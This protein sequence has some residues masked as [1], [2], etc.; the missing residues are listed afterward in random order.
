[1]S[2]LVVGMLAIA[3]ALTTFAKDGSVRIHERRIFTISDE[4][5][6]VLK[7]VE[8]QAWDLSG[9]ADTLQTASR[10]S[11][12]TR[13]FHAEELERVRQDVNA[14]GSE[15]QRLQGLEPGESAWEQETVTRVMPL[16]RQVAATTGRTIGYLNEYPGRIGFAEYGHLTKELSDQSTDLSKAL[17][18]SIHL[19][20]LRAKEDHLRAQLQ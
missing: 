17:H 5:E 11:R 7:D 20:E 19:A 2:K 14:I 3:G 10:N 8:H 18:D 16:L 12:S 13:E 4:A 6:N 9:H 15:M 1:M